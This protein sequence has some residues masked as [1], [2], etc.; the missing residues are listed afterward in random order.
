[1]TTRA[2]PAIEYGLIAA[3]IAAVVITAVY[4][5][6]SKVNTHL[7]QHQDRHEVIADSIRDLGGPLTAGHQ[8][9]RGAVMGHRVSARADG[10]ARRAQNRRRRRNDIHPPRRGAA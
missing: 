4:N 2:P 3:G 8:H 6:G 1:V 5:L 9:F 7:H 10:Q